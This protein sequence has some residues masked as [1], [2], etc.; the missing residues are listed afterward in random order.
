MAEIKVN[1]FTIF[2]TILFLQFPGPK[3]QSKCWNIP[4][5]IASFAALESMGF[6]YFFC[7]CNGVFHGLKTHV[8]YNFGVCS[9]CLFI[10][11]CTSYDGTLY[12]WPQCA[13]SGYQQDQAQR[14]RIHRAT[15]HNLKGEKYMRQ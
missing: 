4:Y 1:E 11:I 14:H 5:R 10:F 12:G 8:V 7:V 2:N 6:Q 9:C 13:D 15:E 3:K